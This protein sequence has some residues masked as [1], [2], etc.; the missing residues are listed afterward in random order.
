MFLELLLRL[1]SIFLKAYLNDMGTQSPRAR[2][3]QE[4]NF[5]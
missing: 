5:I 1:K 2:L 4:I 3:F